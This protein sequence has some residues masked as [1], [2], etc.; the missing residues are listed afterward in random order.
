MFAE[1]LAMQMRMNARRRCALEA[2]CANLTYMDLCSRMQ[3]RRDV[4]LNGHLGVINQI[5]AEDGS[6]GCWIVT[7]QTQQGPQ[8]VFIRTR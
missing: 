1:Q 2:E 8:E 7:V 6:G 3:S 5:Q 4:V